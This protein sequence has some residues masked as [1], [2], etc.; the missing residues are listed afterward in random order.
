MKTKALFIVLFW[1][2]QALVPSSANN[3][4]IFGEE[5]ED[6]RY[7]GVRSRGMRRTERKDKREIK[8]SKNWLGNIR[9]LKSTSVHSLSVSIWRTVQRNESE[10]LWYLLFTD[11]WLLCLSWYQKGDVQGTWRWNLAVKQTPRCAWRPL[12]GGLWTDSLS[13]SPCG[14]VAVLIGSCDWLA[15]NLWLHA[16]EFVALGLENKSVGMTSLA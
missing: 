3:L 9:K 4:A 12:Q 8:W 16:H 11:V 2:A 5:R 7:R 10:R 15:S 1:E 14:P 6:M 13:V